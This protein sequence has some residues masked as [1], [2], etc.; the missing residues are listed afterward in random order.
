MLDAAFE[1]P[2]VSFAHYHVHVAGIVVDQRLAQRRA[3]GDG[4]LVGLSFLDG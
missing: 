4:R 2:I 1:C 3:I